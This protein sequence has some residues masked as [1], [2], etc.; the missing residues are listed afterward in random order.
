MP[1]EISDHSKKTQ[2]VIALGTVEEIRQKTKEDGLTSKQVFKFCP[3]YDTPEDL[4][5]AFNY[6]GVRQVL[7]KQMPYCNPLNSD[8]MSD[9]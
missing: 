7:Q 9:Y 2:T 8:E 1:Q 5:L 3:V 4:F 6:K